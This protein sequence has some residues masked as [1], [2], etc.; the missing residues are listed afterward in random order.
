MQ[1]WKCSFSSLFGGTQGAPLTTKDLVRWAYEI[2]SGMEYVS[3]KNVTN[4]V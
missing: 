2:A 4:G 3:G 1:I